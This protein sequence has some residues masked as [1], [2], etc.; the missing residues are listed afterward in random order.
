M[1]NPFELKERTWKNVPSCDSGDP[2]NT[3][4]EDNQYQGGG[5]YDGW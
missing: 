4:Q 5:N 2:D 3:H 1:R